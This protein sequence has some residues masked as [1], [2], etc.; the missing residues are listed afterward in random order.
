MNTENVFQTILAKLFNHSNAKFVQYIH[1]GNCEHP[2]ADC[3]PKHKRIFENNNSK[4][5]VGWINHPHCDCRY[6]D[7][8]TMKV[9]TVSNKGITSPDVYLKAYGHLPDYYITKDEA[10][11][12]GW[13][14]GKNL[15][16]FAPGKMIG[17]DEYNNKKHILPEKEG[18]KWREC[19]VDYTGLKRNS[20]RLYYSSD[21]LVFYSP[22]HLDGDVTVYQIK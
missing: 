11:K 15:A 6:R 16:H 20:L 10:R 2:C 3:P 7:V 8:E 21:G 14:E 17:G 13:K 18:R 12:L 1:Q 9:G 4:P 22:D 19:D 5:K